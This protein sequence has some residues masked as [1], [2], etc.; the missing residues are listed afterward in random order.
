MKH[1]HTFESFL[2][3]GKGKTITVNTHG[4]KK[5]TYSDSDIQSMI[6]DMDLSADN[7]PKWIYVAGMKNPNFP[8]KPQGVL[9]LLK[10]ILAAKG[11]VQ[12]NLASD[13]PHYTWSITTHD[14]VLA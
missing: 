2:N 5:V 14:K 1:I 10:L 13:Q 8:K 7:L 11:D 3:E 6:E 12:I 4:G 9:A